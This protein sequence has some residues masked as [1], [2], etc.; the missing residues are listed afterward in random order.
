[1]T[2]PYKQ[3]ID[4]FHDFLKS[5]RSIDE[6]FARRKPSFRDWYTR[7][8][9]S[10]IIEQGLISEE[11]MLLGLKQEEKQRFVRLRDGIDDA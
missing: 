3:D 1:M 9:V 10:E 8:M 4:Q 5:I 6:F 2:D 7:E 11:A